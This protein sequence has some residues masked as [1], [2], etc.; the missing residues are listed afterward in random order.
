MLISTNTCACAY[1]QRQKDSLRSIRDNQPS[2]RV[3]RVQFNNRLCQQPAKQGG[4]SGM[5]GQQFSCPRRRGKDVTPKRKR[6]RTERANR[7]KNMQN[8]VADNLSA[9]HIYE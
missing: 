7:A 9:T 3:I 1:Y 2:F 5:G 8:A 6:R 4:K